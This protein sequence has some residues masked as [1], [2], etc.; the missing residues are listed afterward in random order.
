MSKVIDQ[1]VVEMQFDNRQFERNVSTT[2]STV[3][4]LKNKLNFTDAAKGL[5]NVSSAAK[6]V[7]MGGLAA[8]VETVHA[9]FSALQVMGITALANITNSAINAGKRIVS[10]LTIDPIKTGFQEYET[11]INAVQTILANTQSKGSTLSDVNAALDELN[12]YADQTIYNFTEMTKNIGTFTAA[13][14]D[15]D[16]SVQSIKGIANLAAVSG[17]T[18]LQASTAMYQLSQALAAGRVSLQDWNS[19]VNAGMGGEVFQNALI[20][21]AR[22]MGTGVDEAIKKYGT[23]RESLTKGQWLTAEVLTETLA[24][25]SGAYTEADLVAQGYSR[26]QAKAIVELANTAVSAATDVKTFTQLWDTLKEAAQSGWTESWEILV[27]DFEE[28]KGLLGELYTTFSEIIGQSAEARNTL[29]YDAMTSNWKKITDGITEAGLSAEDFKDKVTEVAKS[30]GMNIEEIIADYGSLEAA[31]K[32]GALSSDLL[33]EALTKMTGTSSEISKKM[34]DLR[35]KYKTNEDILKALNKAG[36]ENADIQD[37]IGKSAEG[38]T[39]ALNDLSD[40]QLMSIGYTADQVKEIRKLSEYAELAGGSMQE[41]IDNVAVPQGRELLIDTL[42]ISLRSLISVFERVG[43]AWRDVFPPTTSDQLLGIIQSVRDFAL[44]LRPSEETLQKLQSTF[45]GLFSILSIG[46]QALSAILSPIGTLLGRFADLSGGILDTT[47]SFGDWLFELNNTIKTTGSFKV[48]GDIFSDVVNTI[49]DGIETITQKIGGIGGIFSGITT[50]VSTVFNAVKTVVGDAFNWIRDNVTA[51]DIFAGLAGGGVFILFKKFSGLIEKVKELFE[52]FG[53]SIN[54][55][56]FSDILGSVHDSLESFQQGIQ[57]ASLVGIATAVALLSSSMRKISEIEP[58]KI[59]YSLAAIRLMIASLTSGFKSLS[60]TIS[61]FNSSGTVKAS[62]TLIGIATAVNILASA[63]QKMQ[64]LEWDDIAKGLV[65]IG[66]SITTLSSALRIIGKSNVTLRTSIAIIALAEACKMLADALLKFGSMTWDVI[67]RGLASMGIALGELTAVMAV[68]SKVGGGKSFLGATSILIAVQS[69]DEIS[70]NLKRL[71][72][73][74]WDEIGRG[75]AAMGGALVEFTAVL[76]ILS[77]IGGFG[78]VLGGTAILIAV[79]SLDEISENLKRLGALTWDEIGRGLTAMGG[80]LGE[81]GLVTGALGKLAGFSGIL[82]A[83]AILIAVQGLHDIADALAKFGSMVWDEIGRGLTAMG[84]A[85]T[86]LGVISG[87]LGKLTGLSGLI[88]AG[89]ILLAVQGLD[90]LANALAKFGSMSWDEIGRGLVGMG[91]AL[92]ELAVISG[93]TGTLTGIAGLVG[94]GTITLASQGLDQL[95]NAFQKFGSMSWDEIG[96]GLSAMGAAMGETALGG[97]LNTFSGFGAAAIAEMAEPLGMLADS[98]R[99]WEGVVVPENLGRQLGMLADGVLAFNFTGWGADAIAAIAGPIGIMAESISKWSGVSIPNTLGDQLMSLSNGVGAFNFTGWGADAIAAV[100]PALGSLADSMRKWTIITIPEGLGD[101]LGSLA[102]GVGAFSFAF[103]GGWSISSLVDPL[104]DLA[105]TVKKWNGVTIPGNI[106]SGMQSL[107]DGV[108]AFNFSFVGGWSIGSIAEPLGDLADSI[109]KWNGVSLS[110]IGTD[111]TSLANGLSSLGNVGIKKLAS[112]FEGSSDRIATATKMMLNSI[113]AN[114]SN[115]KPEILKSFTTLVND[116]VRSV[117]EKSKD[118]NDAGIKLM[119]NFSTGLNDKKSDPTT[120]ISSML[121]KLVSTIRGKYSEF[122]NA[123]TYLVSGFAKGLEN[124]SAATI[125]ARRLASSTITA[126]QKELKIASPSKV[127]RD[128]VGNWIVKGVSEGITED[129]SAEEAASQKAQNITQAFQDEIDMLDLAKETAEL[130]AELQGT[131][132]DYLTEHEGQVKRLELAYGEYQVML[133][134]F[135]ETAAETQQAY[136]KYL[137]EEIDLR[138]LEA[139]ETQRAYEA[140]KEAIESRKEASTMSLVEELSAWKELQA[141]YVEGSEQRLEIDQKVLDLQEQLN[142]ATEEYYNTLNDIQDEANEKRAQIEQD[143][144]DQ[145]AQI[146]EQAEEKRLQLDQQYESE[147]DQ[148]QQDAQQQRLQL[149]Q[150]YEDQKTQIKENAEQKRL[151]LD[152]EYA[153]K[154]KEIND[155]LA[156]DIEELEK[157]YSDAVSS[158]ADTLYGSYGLFD[159]V[160]EDEEK[161]TGDTLISNLQ[162]Q[163]DAFENWT[164][165]INEL[166]SK[167]LDEALIDELRDMGPS[168]AAEIEA[169]NGMSEEQLDQYVEMWKTKHELAKEQ[170]VFELEDMRVETN[171]TIEQLRADAETQLEEY[172]KTWE[173]QV[174]QL[175]VDT[176]IELYELKKDWLAQIEEINGET[177]QKLNELTM[178][179]CDQV[180]ELNEETT[181]ELADLKNNWRQQ[182]DELEEDTAAKLSDLQNTWRESVMG[183]KTETTSEFTKMTAQLVNTLG[184]RYQWSQAGASMIDGVLNGVVSHTP[185]LVAGVEDAMLTALDAAKGALGINSPS[186]EFT[187]LGRYSNEGFING[188]KQYAGM[189]GASAREIGNNAIDGLRESIAKIADVVNGD[190]DVQPTIRPVLDL[191]G[192]ESGASKLNAMF[193]RNQA[194]SISSATRAGEVTDSQNGVDSRKSGNV[195]Q[196]TQNNYSPKALSRVDIYRQT[197][198]QFSKFERMV[199][200]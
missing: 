24:Q 20:R 183:L 108:G 121:T 34:E 42:R 136:N 158:R 86:E 115:K 188:L 12:K 51:G 88:G 105:D 62:I 142:D 93:L 154:T 150:D 16:K 31:F 55:G 4:K 196:F 153:D 145:R 27:G 47:A 30:K 48:V 61:K 107:A 92:T 15:L 125:A 33:N 74:T 191:S 199:E 97:L 25:I 11:Q 2:M 72:A 13:G 32:N 180:E 6:K 50:A 111:L 80:A 118:F 168:S 63:M 91:G 147:R 26:D 68:L 36:Y 175:H 95:A 141:A 9:K 131:S 64:D 114:V 81:I 40:A 157:K 133:E 193:S 85:L 28:A 99:K 7:D 103:V 39:I 122:K 43:A 160:K 23:F 169:L 70:E 137:Q 177:D 8:G 44:T 98:I 54:S 198:N 181:L 18:S 178:N 17:S 132:I 130:E 46:K 127:A 77:K 152:Q 66:V 29:L 148:I 14:V 19:V 155:Q 192:I 123:G 144:E 104:S 139:E 184:N 82:G 65:T 128:K 96:R 78:A 124:N 119:S 3:E 113:T 143:Y 106:D 172:R 69:L 189:V 102:D 112:E 38:Q 166:V 73:L 129:M 179:W 10:A 134:N 176:E 101:D 53:D 164:K 94:A 84:G 35:G 165:N 67:A 146:Q 195:Y 75:L 45:R 60:K 21:T 89:T 83:G 109:K 161:V 71:G 156:A 173:E 182:L 56:G 167:G 174:R 58:V 37:L 151:E 149:S 87:L 1:K 90:D 126:M 79:Q 5:E 187:K 163:L 162:T 197:N 59:A 138:T 120:K 117:N 171:E 41:F 194:L 116:I 22:Q 57:V 135:G 49:F 52:G 200:T 110:G 170:A 190:I 185:E 100:A 76:A 186:K 159:A 140:A